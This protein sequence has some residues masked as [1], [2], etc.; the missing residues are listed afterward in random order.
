MEIALDLA[1]MAGGAG[2]PAFARPQTRQ[3]DHLGEDL[4]GPGTLPALRWAR[5]LPM[6][7]ISLTSLTL[8]VR[9][10]QKSKSLPVRRK[11]DTQPQY[12]F[13][14][15]RLFCIDSALDYLKSVLKLSFRPIRA[16][17]EVSD[18]D[19]RDYRTETGC[20]KFAAGSLSLISLP[21]TTA[22]QRLGHTL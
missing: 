7:D 16:L 13:K 20:S 3:S 2:G 6:D 4:A 22:A 21:P 5:V 12:G 18:R 1:M 9:L 14:V 15:E 8:M 11:N 10:L 17:L 19:D